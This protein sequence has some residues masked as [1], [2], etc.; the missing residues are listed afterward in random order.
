MVARQAYDQVY[1][2]QRLKAPRRLYKADYTTMAADQQIWSPANWPQ[3]FSWIPG[4]GLDETAPFLV[5]FIG[6]GV[7][8]RLWRSLSYPPTRRRNILDFLNENRRKFPEYNIA[9]KNGIKKLIA[10]TSCSLPQSYTLHW[11][12]SIWKGHLFS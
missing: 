9:N 4:A 1:S 3:Y 8:Y 7:I 12:S 11:H 2:N 6:I 5:Q 10:N